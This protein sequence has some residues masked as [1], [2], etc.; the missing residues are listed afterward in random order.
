MAV[1]WELTKLV[2]SALAG[3]GMYHLVDKLLHRRRLK[4]AMEMDVN[5]DS[6]EEE[7]A[8]I[9][10]EDDEWPGVLSNVFHGEVYNAVRTA[11]PGLYAEIAGDNHQL[12]DVY[13]Q[14]FRYNELHDASVNPDRKVPSSDRDLLLEQLRDTRDR[15]RGVRQRVRT[16]P[17]WS[18]G[19]V[20]DWTRRLRRLT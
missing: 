14:L 1:T 11:D 19:T 18:F 9:E 2:L 13:Q 7:I 6:L 16:R 3:A 15:L 17:I 4:Q 12:A 5:L 10:R 8:A 20:D